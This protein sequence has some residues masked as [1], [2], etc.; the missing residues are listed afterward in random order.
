L[1]PTTPSISTLIG[2]TTE[3]GIEQ[4]TTAA[5]VE[6][7]V[8]T[9]RTP[10]TSQVVATGVPSESTRLPV[11]NT[12]VETPKSESITLAP[13][14]S[15]KPI[16]HAGESLEIKTTPT[17]TP[18]PNEP[19]ASSTVVPASNPT[20]A[21]NGA[22]SS[23][24]KDWLP[25]QIIQE[26]AMAS[27]EAIT[28]A[29][30]AP[31]ATSGLPRAITPATTSN[32]GPDYQVITVGFKAQLNYRFVVEN[33]L[34]SAQIFQYLP[35]LLT[36]PFDTSQEYKNVVVKR[37]VPYS[38]DGID[39]TIT[40]A[41]VYFPADSVSSLAQFIQTPGSLLF[42]N[43]DNTQNTLA[44]LIDSRIP[45]TGLDTSSSSGSSSNS[46]SGNYAAGSLDSVPNESKNISGGRIAGIT[47]G[48]AAGCVIYMSLMFMLFQKFKKRKNGVELPD[49]ESSVAMDERS[50]SSN[51]SAIFDRLN[52]GEPSTDSGANL[53]ISTP[54]N[55]SNS[56]GWAH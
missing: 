43:P 12:S 13:V 5:I 2:S 36:Y 19:T 50:E 51:F 42:R 47:V 52:S 16:S 34:S 10:Q 20:K 3:V 48:S 14:V 8:E 49:S 9:E 7:S 21:T 56:L 31:T 35:L 41:E 26:S 24:T 27:N 22:E 17:I 46:G 30:N 33:A 39:Y 32:P 11:E 6:S 25:T 37:L 15:Q 1:A 45:L 38:A 40:V 55:A 44:N 4:L 29:S 23:T 54:V 28:Q 53:Q 18:V